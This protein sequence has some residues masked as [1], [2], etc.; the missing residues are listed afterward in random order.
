M[1]RVP[2]Q[3][4]SEVA[5]G[6]QATNIATPPEAFGVG[7]ARA[8]EGLGQNIAR[9]GDELFSRA[10][11]FQNL[12]N[13]TEAR[14]ADL[15]LMGELGDLH[16]KYDSLEGQARVDAFPK[17]KQDI[18]DAHQRIRG[19]ISNDGARRMY[20]G[21]ALSTI[22]RT[23]FNGAGA[24]ASAQ[25]QWM[26]KTADAEI[27]MARKSVSDSPFDEANLA[28]QE[29]KLTRAVESKVQLLGGD[30]SG[31]VAQALLKK[32]LSGLYR[33]KIAGGAFTDAE[34]AS[35]M[36]DN[37]KTKMTPEDVKAAETAV[38]SKATSEGSERIADDIFREGR[39]TATKPQESLES[40]QN[41]AKAEAE[42]QFPNNK[43]MAQHAVD[44]LA[45][46]WNQT[47]HAETIEQ[48][49]NEQI[50][51]Q[52]IQD[53]KTSAEIM[54][55]PVSKTAYDALPANS[56]LKKK[57]LEAQVRG[58]TNQKQA[59]E[60]VANYKRLRALSTNDTIEFLNTRLD[61]ERLSE[62]DYKN[63]MAMRDKIIKGQQTDPRV[64]P[65]MTVLRNAVGP[66]LEA[67]QVFKRTEA[68][69]IDYDHFT[70]NLQAAL[71]SHL[72]T[73]GK[74]PTDKEL[75]DEIFPTLIQP[76]T[77]PG[78][79]YGT[80]EYPV[81]KAPTYTQGYK[82]FDQKLRADM[83]DKGRSLSDEEVYRAYT[84][85]LYNKFYRKPLKDAQ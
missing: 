19:S 4:Y 2:Y 42:R 68:N 81:F 41:R 76:H 5:P 35:H 25:K 52:S 21:N 80:N 50:I 49:K 56:S 55:D 43:I 45:H 64:G 62:G 71:D 38:N 78:R 26:D 28:I 8:T 83:T 22:G 15:Q 60:M 33:E 23:I 77:F 14:Q 48:R 54:S 46:R 11:A 84:Q 17:Y 69:K 47:T 70:Q 65:A 75:I 73:K 66:Q 79:F 29:A 53:G 31:P 18:F 51:Y 16:A 1:P 59:D 39:G 20:D 63:L 85:T 27:F 58:Y 44:K 12:N 40:M 7:V 9:T 32:E 72:E 30:M 82:D 34:R 10:V 13:E 6:D 37:L 24:A 74:K 3:P 57:P 67:L 36:L 61:Q